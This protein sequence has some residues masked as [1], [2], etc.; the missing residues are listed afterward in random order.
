MDLTVAVTGILCPAA[1]SM[2]SSRERMSHSR[3]G[4]MTFRRGIERHDG[5]FEADL[6]VALAGRAVRNCIRAD[7]VRHVHQMFGDQGARHRRAE[8]VLALVHR[9][10]TQQREKVI[11][12]RIL[13]SCHG[14]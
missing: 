14:R 4:A 8:Q 13:P 6:V 12:W 11:G 5:Q 1:Y 3:Q 2:A 10:G 9:S 7:F